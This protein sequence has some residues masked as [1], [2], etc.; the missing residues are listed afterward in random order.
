MSMRQQFHPAARPGVICQLK[1]NPD[2]PFSTDNSLMHHSPV[3]SNSESLLSKTKVSRN[4]SN[5][6]LTTSDPRTPV[7]Q[8]T[9]LPSNKKRPIEKGVSSS[10]A[11]KKKTKWTATRRSSKTLEPNGN[12]YEDQECNLGSNFKRDNSQSPGGVDIAKYDTLDSS[13]DAACS[14]SKNKRL[15]LGESES[16]S[17]GTTVYVRGDSDAETLPA[18]GRTCRH[19]SNRAEVGHIKFN[20]ACREEPPTSE[21]QESASSRHSS[22]DIYSTLEN[23]KAMERRGSV[24]QTPVKKVISWNIS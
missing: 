21:V 9:S 12:I 7:H 17:H 18:E 24:Y 4:S 6:S 22:E 13:K 11:S 3:I 14:D 16:K 1:I 5:T 20:E 10:S 15:H 19:S 8:S 23:G 2:K